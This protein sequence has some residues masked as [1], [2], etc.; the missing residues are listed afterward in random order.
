MEPGSH[1]T[2]LKTQAMDKPLSR[3]GNNFQQHGT[4]NGHTAHVVKNFM[5]KADGVTTAADLRQGKQ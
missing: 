4:D 1:V 3:L 5:T 2:S